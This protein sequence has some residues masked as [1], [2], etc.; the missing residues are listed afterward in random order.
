MFLKLLLLYENYILDSVKVK[1]HQH[2]HAEKNICNYSKIRIV[3][4]VRVKEVVLSLGNMFACNS[5][6]FTGLIDLDLNP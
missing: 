5:H 4:L 1:R 2:Q 6:G 3:I